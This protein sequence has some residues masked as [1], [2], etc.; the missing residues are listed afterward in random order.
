MNFQEY[1]QHIGYST[2]NR[3]AEDIAIVKAEYHRFYQRNYHKNYRKNVKRVE[4]QFGK[5]EFITI[6]K[7]AEFYGEKPRGFIR[8]AV[9]C[10]MQSE[11][12]IPSKSSLNDIAMLIRRSANNINQLVYSSHR[13][14]AIYQ[15]NVQALV[16][17][18]STMEQ[19]LRNF[20]QKPTTIYRPIQSIK[21]LENAD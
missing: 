21:P 2:V 3:S 17:E 18:V 4:I 15:E 7:I 9:L 19:N 1:L 14:Q 12:Y 11:T 8:K 13:N 5:K 10:F 6:Q 16:I 20:Y